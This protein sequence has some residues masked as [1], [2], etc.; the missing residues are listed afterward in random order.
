MYTFY[1]QILRFKAKILLLSP[2]SVS[3][4]SAP[5]LSR[6]LSFSTRAHTPQLFQFCSS[7]I[8]CACLLYVCTPGQNMSGYMSE[9]TSSPLVHKQA[10]RACSLYLH[11]HAA[12]ITS[13]HFSFLFNILLTTTQQSTTHTHTT[14]TAHTFY[15]YTVYMY[16]SHPLNALVFD[17]LLIYMCMCAQKPHVEEQKTKVPHTVLHICPHWFCAHA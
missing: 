10:K 7:W 3:L 6:S 14:H 8:L 11:L 2:L 4:F 16:T 9:W 5:S 13:K 1:A 12:G 15:V 17:I